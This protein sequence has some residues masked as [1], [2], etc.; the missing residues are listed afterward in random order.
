MDI[1]TF[2]KRISYQNYCVVGD[3]ISS[4]N[5]VNYSNHTSI[6]SA[7]S[8]DAYRAMINYKKEADAFDLV[9][10]GSSLNTFTSLFK[11]DAPLVY[12]YENAKHKGLDTFDLEFQILGNKF[13]TF[14][15]DKSKV[16]NVDKKNNRCI[17]YTDPNHIS[18]EY[19][20]TKN[21]FFTMNYD[22]GYFSFFDYNDNRTII[23]ASNF[24]TPEKLVNEKLNIL[25]IL[26]QTIEYYKNYDILQPDKT[27]KIY[28]DEYG[29]IK[30]IPGI[31][32]RYE[33]IW[34]D[35]DGSIQ[36]IINFHPL[37]FDLFD[38]D[39]LQGSDR[40]WAVD[41]LKF[42]YNPVVIFTRNIYKV[43]SIQAMKDYTSNIIKFERPIL[44]S[45]SAME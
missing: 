27:K 45:D 15:F 42:I 38:Y 12:T 19:Q 17:A 26:P 43:T 39:H 9:D 6:Q 3:K 24:Y 44:E 2:T 4:M 32:M 35:E 8:F 1:E 5:Y 16:V 21:G 11:N 13:I 20:L 30:N 14:T 31:N 22:E 18:E 34:N 23:K 33:R 7:R 37:Y 40:Y 25:S 28:Y 10:I 29:M 41:E 36:S